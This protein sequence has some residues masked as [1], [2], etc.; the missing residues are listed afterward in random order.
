MQNQRLPGRLLVLAV[1]P[2]G[3][4]D[5][6]LQRFREVLY[7]EVVDGN[8]SC[9]DVDRS[10]ALREVRAG[11]NNAIG[12]TYPAVLFTV[13]PR[14]GSAEPGTTRVKSSLRMEGHHIVSMCSMTSSVPRP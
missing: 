13:T 10:A 3:P 1:G 14:G 2:R 12:D 7:E 6:F 9:R 5:G 11:L 4:V 8:R